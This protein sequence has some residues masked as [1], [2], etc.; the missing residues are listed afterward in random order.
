MDHRMAPLASTQVKNGQADGRHSV[1]QLY[2]ASDAAKR[3]KGKAVLG[4]SSA[5][6]LLTI[7]KAASSVKSAHA[8]QLRS[9]GSVDDCGGLGRVHGSF[10][11]PGAVGGVP[12]RPAV[13]CAVMTVIQH[14]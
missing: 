12:F 9:G 8:G 1:T 14:S 5:P 2:A 11:G 13:L 10:G 4:Q 7:F 3:T 6:Y